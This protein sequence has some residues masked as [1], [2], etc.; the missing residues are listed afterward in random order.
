MN[1]Y[2]GGKVIVVVSCL[3]WGVVVDVFIEVLFVCEEEFEV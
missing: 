1:K 3:Y 2:L